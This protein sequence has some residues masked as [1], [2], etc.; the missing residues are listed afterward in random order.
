MTLIA[1]SPD[2]RRATFRIDSKFWATFCEVT[3]G[4]TITLPFSDDAFADEPFGV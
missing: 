2:R 4:S 1:V 3:V